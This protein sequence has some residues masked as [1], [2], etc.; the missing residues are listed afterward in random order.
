M[1]RTLVP[2]QRRNMTRRLLSL[3][4]LTV[5]AAV[6]AGAP[7]QA[8]AAPIRV[9][10]NT[11]DFGAFANPFW[12]QAR[13]RRVRYIVRYDVALRR[14]DRRY[15][16][17]YVSAARRNGVQVLMTFQAPFSFRCPRSRRC[18]APSARKYRRA[19]RAFRR[20]FPSVRNIIPWNEV[21]HRSQPTFRK[22]RAAATYYKIVKRNCRG[23]TVVAADVIDERNMVSYLR[24]FKRYVRGRRLWGL[25]NY[26]DTNPR[27]GQTFGGTRKLLRTVRGSVWL[28]ESGGI[29]YFRLPN[30]RRLFRRSNARANRALKRMFRIARR[31]RRRIKRIY[32]YDW[33]QQV[34]RNRFDAGLL[35]KSGTPRPG[36]FTVRNR[37]RGRQ[38]RP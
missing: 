19:F 25:H 2:D 34:R 18:K 3:V 10:V 26:K 5:V 33:Q 1:T 17:D 22:P 38:F 24:R 11:Q 23:C 6:L 16:T 29:V 14:R 15:L 20:R 8:D 37:L 28:A 13:F 27:R 7:A 9:G 35:N 4:A 31:Y 12:K 36:Y 32:V 21:N 30:G